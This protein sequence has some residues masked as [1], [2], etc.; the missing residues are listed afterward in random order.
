MADVEDR[1]QAFSS[2]NWDD[3]QLLH[4]VDSILR[5]FFRSYWD[6]DPLTRSQVDRLRTAAAEAAGSASISAL[7]RRAVLTGFLDDFASIEAVLPIIRESMRGGIAGDEPG[8]ATA[9]GV[10]YLQAVNLL[11]VMRDDPSHYMP[12]SVQTPPTPALR[13]AQPPPRES[14][15]Q[16]NAGGPARRGATSGQKGSTAPFQGVARGGEVVQFHTYVDFP[17]TISNR[18][19]V[20]YPLVV[21]LVR[22]RPRESRS[23]AEVGIAFQDEI[24]YVD[25]VV[26]APG[27]E[28]VSGYGA[29]AHD[30]PALRRTIAVPQDGDSQPAVFLMQLVDD[31]TGPHRVTVDFYHRGR[32]AGSLTLEVAVRSFPF[33]GRSTRRA[34]AIS[35]EEGEEPPVF[36]TASVVRAVDGVTISQGTPLPAADIELRIIQDADGRTLHFHLHSQKLP[37]LDG[38]SAGSIVFNDLS[39]PDLFFD[40]LAERLS[41][42]AARAGTELTGEE[43]ARMEDEVAD[44]GVELYEQ[45]FPAPLRQIYWEMKARRDAGEVRNL[46]IVSDEPWIPWELVKPYDVVD[47]NDVEDDHLAGAW[48]M[49][50]WLAGAAVPADLNIRAARLIAPMLSLDFVTSEMQYFG[51]LAARQIETAPPISTRAQF[52]ELAEEGGAQLFHFA[53]HGNYNQA[54]VDESPIVLEGDPLFPS[55]LT[56]RRAR[57]LRREKPLIFL[58]T[59][60]GARVG[61]NLTGLGGWAQRLVDHLGVTAFV[62]A[63]WEVHDELASK[64]AQIFYEELWAGK[65]LG[66]AFFSSRQQIRAM[67]SANPTWL[68]YT[69]YGDPNS[70][71]FCP[72]EGRSASPG[73]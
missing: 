64:F 30:G 33:L 37:A 27:F 63:L 5:R 23:Q 59:C 54:F 41:A 45:L 15:G 22:D 35:G 68:A 48:R 31:Q 26:R 2:R 16:P 6:L 50:R 28:E 57:G 72:S 32:N 1:R 8:Y 24:E 9:M 29:G 19:D 69:L 4:I 13:G 14:S 65:T 34:E 42:L 67:Q 18:N 56:R 62:G 38:R 39:R 58:N 66:E 47:G 61:Y 52:L 21:Q 36:G 60:H 12:R 51:S 44:L 49:S 46:L 25:V 73:R 70:R 40:R 7:E 71:V 55:D 10:S 43:A 20:K 53:T 11:R 17:P 3:R